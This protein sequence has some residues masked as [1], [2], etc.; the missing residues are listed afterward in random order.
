MAKLLRN[1]IIFG[2]VLGVLFLALAPLLTPAPSPPAL[3]V[4]QAPEF[5]QNGYQYAV[6]RAAPAVVS[7]RTAIAP[8]TASERLQMGLGSG[9][10]LSSDGYIVTNFHVI[11]AAKAIAI[12]VSDGRALSARVIGQDP[13]TDLAVLKVD[14][15][16]LTPIAIAHDAGQVGE[17]ALAI[18]YPFLLGQTV[19]QGII[20]AT[21]RLERG[22]VRLVQTDA[23]I[24]RGNSG[25]ALINAKGELIGINSEVLPTQLGVQGIGFAIPVELVQKIVQQ[26]VRDGR[27]IRGSIGFTGT[28]SLSEMRADAEHWQLNAVHIDNVDPNGAAAQAGLQAGDYISH[29]N[30]ELIGGVTDLLQKIAETKPGQQIR[31]KIR[32]AQIGQELTITVT[33][34]ASE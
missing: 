23:A 13:A 12:E 17:I 28:G 18:G 27:V 15:T 10:V 11:Q 20:S 3:P 31:V 9:V 7:I 8:R 2:A 22:F 24:N 21:E 29:V 33:E 32:R 30:G 4:L 34:R 1:A 14:N 6:K 16:Q 5:P 19:T 25:G 26:I